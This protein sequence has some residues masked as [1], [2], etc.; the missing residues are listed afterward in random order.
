MD[1]LG[2][3]VSMQVVS[4]VCIAGATLVVYRLLFGIRHERQ[5]ADIQASLR[6]A[7]ERCEALQREL[8]QLTESEQSSSNEVVRVW[9]DGA[10]DSAS[11]SKGV[12]CP[13][14]PSPPHVLSSHAQ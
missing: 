7:E 5:R 1:F 12:K 8:A 3:F 9:M 10:F 2:D 13:A 4:T 6:E 11:Q 14:P